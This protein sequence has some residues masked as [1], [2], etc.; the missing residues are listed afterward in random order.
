MTLEPPFVVILT[1]LTLMARVSVVG[2]RLSGRQV[3]N[4]TESGPYCY[5]CDSVNFPNECEHVE[6][7]ETRQVCF[8]QRYTR[9]DNMTVYRMGCRPSTE[10]EPAGRP[11]TCLLCCN[12]SQCNSLLCDEY[13]ALHRPCYKCDDLLHP[14]D[15]EVI[16]ECDL[17]HEKCFMEKVLTDTYNLRYNVGCLR[18]HVCD[19]LQAQLQRGRRD[20]VITQICASCCD[21]TNC[22]NVDCDHAN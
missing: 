2:G 11:D 6:L 10:C 3:K 4:M 14:G 19:A 16:T 7:C 22:N 18:S 15:C 20:H 1:G 21:G 5:S 9:S 17:K 12:N 13:A 8:T